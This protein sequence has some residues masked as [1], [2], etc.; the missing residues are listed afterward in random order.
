MFIIQVCMHAPILS[1]Y[2]HVIHPSSR[3]FLAATKHSIIYTCICNRCSEKGPDVCFP[4]TS[5]SY[6]LNRGVAA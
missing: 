1:I 6:A 5:D 4:H 2:V 3:R